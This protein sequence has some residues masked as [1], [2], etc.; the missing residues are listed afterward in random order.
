MWQEFCDALTVLTWKPVSIGEKGHGVVDDALWREWTTARSHV[1]GVCRFSANEGFLD[2]VE[3]TRNAEC[4]DDRDRIYGMLALFRKDE[5]TLEAD[6][7]KSVQEVYQAVVEN[8]FDNTHSL[9]IVRLNELLEGGGRTSNLPSSVPDFAALRYRSKV[10]TTVTDACLA[11]YGRRRVLVETDILKAP[12]ARIAAVTGVFQCQIP[13]T[14]SPQEVIENL[15]AA[16]RALK[17]NLVGEYLS[18]GEPTGEAVGRMLCLGWFSERFHPPPPDLWSKSTISDLASALNKLHKGVHDLKFH[19]ELEKFLRAGSKW[20]VGRSVFITDRGHIGLGP[21]SIKPNDLVVNLVDCQMPLAL[22]SESCEKFQ[23][24]GEVYCQGA[25]LGESIIGVVSPHMEC[26]G[27]N[28]GTYTGYINRKT[29][30]LQVE[31]PRLDGVGVP[32][33][34]SRVGHEQEDLYTIWREETTGK[35]FDG[36]EFDPRLTMNELEKRGV[37]FEIFKIV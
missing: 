16:V 20:M 23:L 21:A 14:H 36:H 24:V 15:L 35:K 37:V 12:G 17:L 1:D 33:G 4:S 3:K 11:T 10:L 2:L 13:H 28:L 32:D 29:G 7:T 6:Y 27:R 9:D 19:S 8:Y 30:I 26:V 22:R 5:I 31:D 34:W 25:M 18:T